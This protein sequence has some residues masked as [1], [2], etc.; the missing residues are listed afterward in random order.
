MSK[1][2][3][4]PLNWPAD[5]DSMNVELQFTD[6]T[7]WPIANK[8]QGEPRL[9]K[10]ERKQV[11]ITNIRKFVQK[12]YLHAVALRAIPGMGNKGKQMAPVC[13]ATTSG[14]NLCFTCLPGSSGLAKL[15]LDASDGSAK[16]N[17]QRGKP[18]VIEVWVMKYEDGHG[19]R[20]CRVYIK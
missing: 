3:G 9:V 4:M 14:N 6:G 19:Q 1:R 20:N 7:K 5:L 8:L 17:A 15:G 12:N 11:E 10:V 2:S 16:P 13:I 18:Q